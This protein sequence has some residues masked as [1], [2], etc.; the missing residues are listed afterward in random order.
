VIGIELEALSLATILYCPA[1]TVGTVKEYE[2]PPVA[3]EAVLKT[4]EPNVMLHDA[5]GKK[6]VPVI[7]TLE[8]TNP[9]EADA[10][11]APAANA[12]PEGT[13]DRTN[14][15]KITEWVKA[16]TILANLFFKSLLLFPV[17]LFPHN[18]SH[19]GKDPLQGFAIYSMSNEYLANINL[20]SLR[21]KYSKSLE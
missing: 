15:N 11:I 7:V 5:L 3:F 21:Y 8:P 1:G 6:P 16:R 17:R 14:M 18:P 2:K 20:P 10:V 19:Q 13:R 12:V 9:L 4:V